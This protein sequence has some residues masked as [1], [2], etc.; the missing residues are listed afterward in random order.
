MNLALRRSAAH[1][2]VDSIESPHLDEQDQHHLTRVLRLRRDE[3]VSV[4]NGRGQWRLCRFVDGGGLVV[5]TDI[6]ACERPPRPS[7]VGFAVPKGERPEWIVQKLTEI[8]I[9]RIVILH[10]ERS[11][12]VW[13]AERGVRNVLKLRRVA[14]EAAMQSRRVWLPEIFGPVGLTAVGSL[15]GVEPAAM[16]LAEPDGDPLAPSDACI[17]IGPEGGWSD[18]EL[19]GVERHVGLGE[20]VLRVETAALV[21]AVRMMALRSI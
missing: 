19:A 2:F 14:R 3:I 21:A 5:D 12:T 18:T 1:A 13:D 10:T 16:A 4:T 6:A 20:S 8:G 15:P 11:V 7:T 17:L 9:D